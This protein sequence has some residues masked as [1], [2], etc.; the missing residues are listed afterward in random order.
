MYLHDIHLQL[1]GI[2]LSSIPMTSLL[3]DRIT[4]GYDDWG[5]VCVCLC[6]PVSVGMFVYLFMCL[7]K[8]GGSVNLWYFFVVAIV[9][10]SFRDEVFIGLKVN[11]Q[12]WPPKCL[13]FS[14]SDTRHFCI[15]LAFDKRSAH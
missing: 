12:T 3:M 13:Y 7:C 15:Y 9:H 6:V 14:F 1:L 2:V 5:C 11:K 10:N 4:K 8:I